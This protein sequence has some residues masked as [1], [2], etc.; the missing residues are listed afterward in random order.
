MIER[1]AASRRAV[2]HSKATGNLADQD[3]ELIFPSMGKIDDLL[4]GA[5]ER[6]VVHNN[7]VFTVEWS[8]QARAFR[9]VKVPRPSD[10]RWCQYENESDA[11]AVAIRWNDALRYNH[12]G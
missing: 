9:V 12:N 10:A 11:F 5:A 6:A 1:R 4:A 8:P 7:Q 2:R 3:H